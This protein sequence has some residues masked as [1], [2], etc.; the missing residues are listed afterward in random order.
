MKYIIS[1]WEWLVALILFIIFLIWFL[2]VASIWPYEKY[3][4]WVRSYLQLFFKLLFIRIELIF[5][6]PINMDD[7]HIFMPNHVSMFDI[8]L[9]LATIPQNFWG[10]QAASHFKVPLYGWVLKKYGNFP[11]DRSNARASY[12]TMMSAADQVKAGKN[13]LIFPEGTRST[14]P[15]MGTF[16]KLP[17]VMVKRADAP[18]IPMALIGLWDINNKTSWLIKPKKMKVVFGKEI[19]RETIKSLSED[20]LK[21]LT[22]EKIEA[23]IKKFT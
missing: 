9:V 12:K 13:I 3:V 4:V 16:K 7:N 8:P 2:V 17:F 22:K 19:D 14:K 5:E 1:I 18:I 20:E 10:I 6:S 15:S 21:T 23:L 11:I